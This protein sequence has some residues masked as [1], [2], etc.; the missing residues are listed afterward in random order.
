MADKK[1]TY[2]PS[3]PKNIKHD[4]LYEFH[5]NREISEEMETIAKLISR[6][7]TIKIKW[8]ADNHPYLYGFSDMGT[9]FFSKNSKLIYIRPPAKKGNNNG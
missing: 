1:I 4:V 6:G 8:C 5:E 9:V 3:I 7:K 2:I